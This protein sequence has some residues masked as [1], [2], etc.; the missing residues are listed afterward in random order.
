MDRFRCT[1][2]QCFFGI[3][4]SLILVLLSLFVPTQLW[5]EAS[6]T[7]SNDVET[8]GNQA[9]AAGQNLLIFDG[10]LENSGDSGATINSFTFS[11]NDEAGLDNPE[12]NIDTMVVTLGGTT[13]QL[14]VDSG[15]T[16]PTYTADLG[17]PISANSSRISFTVKLFA[18]DGPVHDDQF[19]LVF[20]NINATE[21]TS[22]KTININDIGSSDIVT[23]KS[24]II[25]YENIDEEFD[26]IGNVTLPDVLAAESDRIPLLYME[27][28]GQNNG[29]NPTLG[30]SELKFRVRQLLGEIIPGGTLDDRFGD[31]REVALI[32]SDE[33]LYQNGSREELF[34][35]PRHAL[36]DT[37]PGADSYVIDFAEATN[38]AAPPPGNDNERFSETTNNVSYYITVKTNNGWGEDAEPRYRND[39]YFGYGDAWDAW[40]DTGAISLTNGVT[41]NDLGDTTV[42]VTQGVM[43]NGFDDLVGI[44][45]EVDKL[46][47]NPTLKQ[48]DNVGLDFHPDRLFGFTVLG[49]VNDD[50]KQTTLDSIKVEFPRSSANFVP[51]DDLRS[52]KANKFS[53]LSVWYNRLPINSYGPEDTLLP[54]SP[55]NSS[56]IS[57]DTVTL[58]LKDGFQL[59]SPTEFKPG[60]DALESGRGLKYDSDVIYIA[61][62]QD[63]TGNRPDTFIARIPLGGVQFD[64]GVSADEASVNE[65]SPQVHRYRRPDEISPRVATG[66]DTAQQVTSEFSQLTDN[67][68][69]IGAPSGPIPIIGINARDHADQVGTQGNLYQV[70]LTFEE[71]GESNDFTQDDL[72]PLSNDRTSGV[73]IFRDDKDDPDN[74]PGK[75][76][77]Q[78][79]DLVPL[80]VSDPRTRKDAPTGR[81]E[82][83]PLVRLIMDNENTEPLAVPPDDSDTNAGDDFFITVN[84]SDNAD[85]KDE[86]SAVIGNPKTDD[87]VV[88]RID[89]INDPGT[90]VVTSIFA[91]GESAST[92]RYYSDRISVNTINSFDITPNL[93]SNLTVD[94]SG[95]RVKLFGMNVSDGTNGDQTLEEVTTPFNFKANSDSTDIRPLTEGKKSGVSLYRD[96]GDGE[97]EVNEDPNIGLSNPSWTVNSGTATVNLTPDTTV[98]I[99]DSDV[100]GLDD[101][102]VVARGSKTV[103]IGDTFSASNGGGD[104][105]FSVEESPEDE[106]GTTALI[107]GSLPILI[108]NRTRKS[109]Q[110]VKRSDNPFDVLGINSADLGPDDE[111]LQIVTVDFDDVE[112]S[113]F[114]RS[115]I[116]SLSRSPSSGVGIWRDDN[117]NGDFDP[118]S[119]EFLKPDS[120]PTFDAQNQ[121]ELQFINNTSIEDDTSIPDD[122]DNKDDFFVVLR[123]SNTISH[124]DDFRVDIPVGGIETTQFSNSG[125]GRTN[126]IVFESPNA[127]SIAFTDTGLMADYLLAEVTVSGQDTVAL[128]LAKDRDVGLAPSS[129]ERVA[130]RSPDEP[131]GSVFTFEE[132]EVS[133]DVDTVG[134]VARAFND[135]G[136]TEYTDKEVLTRDSLAGIDLD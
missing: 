12:N 31:F 11:F 104:V 102:F 126:T 86:F 34:S 57:S 73:A 54:I 105:R 114:G 27:F 112:E 37:P 32:R 38:D 107:T 3:K 26:S 89:Y 88:P 64:Q 77:P 59:P 72:K 29:D 50:G 68:Q 103:G 106:A 2:K 117:S 49:S 95:R 16:G 53:G 55:E 101:F 24:L 97:F 45:S 76:D 23:I 5:A 100:S 78:I 128:R 119:D 91:K 22:G 110:R 93:N 92:D 131:G 1:E 115:D 52:L 6:L 58:E 15:P 30:F 125:S 14:D 136:Y 19:N 75:F 123:V 70:D 80:D 35:I 44:S 99:P 87:R 48:D 118:G 67:N 28:G 61:A 18:L 135:S 69:E 109:L 82:E 4:L 66:N 13:A 62:L 96:D 79:D 43:S 111:D 120:A 60:A 21:D 33:K 116:K 98:E 46:L 41:N 74:S 10:S 71:P 47:G 20:E 124:A 94:V 122:F 42:D 39:Q 132:V 8:V 84:I 130:V 134:I 127:A 90:S 51:E 36:P 85:N 40:L 65:P 25:P 56:W 17:N 108:N 63:R 133:I 9:M 113:N 7:V 81:G 129:Y 121:V 83:S